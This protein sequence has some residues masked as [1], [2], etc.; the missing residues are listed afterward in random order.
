MY[1]PIFINIT[2]LP[3]P[4]GFKLDIND[5]PTCQCTDKLDIFGI[6]NCTVTNGIGLV[7]CSGTVWVGHSGTGGNE[8]DVVL[9][10]KYCPYDYCKVDDIAV[11]LYDPDTQCAFNHNGILCGGCPSNLSLALG[12]SQCLPCTNDGFALVFFIK[13]LDLTVARGTINGLIFYAN[14]IW[15]N[16]SIFFP[17]GNSNTN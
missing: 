10:N 2:I 1:T 14:I 3:C 4:L 5:L 16:Q 11:D 7:Y 9:V 13:I 15:I 17:N 12:S 8:K 6:D